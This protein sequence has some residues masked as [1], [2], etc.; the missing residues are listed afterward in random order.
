[1]LA[2]KSK[3][4]A[5][6]YGRC[7][8]DKMKELQR[9]RLNSFQPLH[10]GN[11]LCTLCNSSRYKEQA[12]KLLFR[13]IL[14]CRFLT[15]VAVCKCIAVRIASGRNRYRFKHLQLNGTITSFPFLV[16]FRSNFFW[17]VKYFFFKSQ[18]S[19]EYL[20]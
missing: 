2:T 11:N 18:Y 3:R 6:I 19:S 10:Y 13:Q 4:Q 15:V 17:L 20:I 1:M 8:L 5:L 12:S 9:R 7:S 14:H 16:M